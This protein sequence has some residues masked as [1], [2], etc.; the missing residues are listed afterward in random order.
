MLKFLFV[1]SCNVE[2]V[3]IILINFFL[4][5][6]YSGNGSNGTVKRSIFAFTCNN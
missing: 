4:L 1:I 3:N 5:A 6:Q 2:Y